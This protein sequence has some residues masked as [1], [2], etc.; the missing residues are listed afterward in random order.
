MSAHT[1][2]PWIVEKS[3]V[4]DDFCIYT[5]AKDPE[6]GEPLY[7]IG[8]IWNLSGSPQNEANARLIAAAPELLAALEDLASSLHPLVVTLA[9]GTVNVIETAEVTA[10]RAAILKAKGGAA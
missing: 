2:G 7:G 6:D 3:R 1:E 10:A 5:E 8:Q 9:D 4:G